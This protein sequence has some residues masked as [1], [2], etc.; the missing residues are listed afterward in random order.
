[1]NINFFRMLWVTCALQLLLRKGSRIINMS[2]PRG[3][4]PA[5]F[6]SAYRCIQVRSEKAW[7]N[8]LTTELSHVEDEA[9]SGVYCLPSD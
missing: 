9:S 2:L 8:D 1:M 3:T 5:P 6:L 7:S 4:V